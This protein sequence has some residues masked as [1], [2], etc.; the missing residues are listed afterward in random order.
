VSTFTPHRRKN[1]FFFL[2]ENRKTFSTATVT[3]V[4]N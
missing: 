4:V 1:T 2:E 3:F